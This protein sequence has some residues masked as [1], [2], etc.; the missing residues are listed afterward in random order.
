MPKKKFLFSFKNVVSFQKSYFVLKN[1]K[2]QTLK[3]H[4]IKNRREKAP[5]LFIYKFKSYFIN[6]ECAW[7]LKMATQK[8]DRF[9]HS[10]GELYDE[11]D[12]FCVKRCDKRR[13]MLH[14]E[15]DKELKESTRPK[16]F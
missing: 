10:R 1:L 13:S 7:I 11:N 2:V 8:V 3:S 4:F 15:D 5:V 9:Y 6:I 16:S 14:S 12:R